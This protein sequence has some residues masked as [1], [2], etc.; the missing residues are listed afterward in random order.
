MFE[1]EVGRAATTTMA[2]GELVVIDRPDEVPLTPAAVET[3]KRQADD[4]AIVERDWEAALATRGVAPGDADRYRRAVHVAIDRAV[5]MLRCEQPDWLTM[6]L[7]ERPTAPASAAVWDDAVTRIASFRLIH[8]VP[9]G[10][11]G[12]GERPDDPDA[13]DRWHRLMLRLLE[14]R[15]WL[16]DHVTPEPIQ[17][18]ARTPVELVERRDE[19]ERLLASAPDDQRRLIHHLVHSQ[20]DPAELHEQLAATLAAQGDRRDRIVAHAPYLVELEQINLLIA[21]Q[22]PLAHWPAAQPEP[23]RDALEQLRRLAPE[24]DAREE[25]TLAEI[26][27]LTAE[28]DPVCSLEVRRQDLEALKARATT[29]AERE[30][31]CAELSTVRSELRHARKEQ[32][33]DGAFRRHRPDPMTHARADRV[34]TLMH[35]VLTDQPDWLVDYIRHLHD[36]GQLDGS[37]LVDLASWVTSAAAELDRI[38]HLPADWPDPVPHPRAIDAPAPC[39]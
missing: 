24:P 18:T 30:I 20:A 32:A 4:L 34:A 36:V 29:P 3:L 10:V 17:V 11:E 25:R 23:V 38:G 2:W 37:S 22:E 9:A 21:A 39:M 31:L 26:D 5:Q 27:R 19:L 35:D 8:H 1:N 14:D 16:A 12:L 33:V 6:W 7:G 13:G 15:C 28:N